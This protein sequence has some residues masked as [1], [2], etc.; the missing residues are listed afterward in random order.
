MSKYTTGE[1]AKLCDVSVRTV[2]FYDARGVLHPSELT[3]GG[4]RLYTDDDLTK[5]RLV[6]ILKA[7]GLSLDSIK[8]ILESDAPE[9]ILSLLLDEQLKHL[10]G[11]IKERQRQIEVIKVIKESVRNMIAA[12]VNSIQDIEHMMKNKKSLRKVQGALIVGCVFVDLI[13]ISAALLWIIKGIWLPFAV[14]LPFTLLFFFLIFR[15]Y[16]K[17]T[18]YTCPECNKTFRPTFRETVFAPR[19]PKARRLTCTNCG[20]KG[21][22]VEVYAKGEVV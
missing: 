15:M 20:N 11:E 4:R 6:C 13:Q 17:N 12:P 19:D 18:A 1:M 21:Y 8:G 2:Q 9:K 14:G 22:C 5:L 7:I 16:H 10:S 3:D